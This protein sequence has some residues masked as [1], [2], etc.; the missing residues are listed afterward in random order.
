MS[1]KKNNAKNESNY[2]LSTLENQEYLFK[3]KFYKQELLVYEENK[4][5]L[6]SYILYSYLILITN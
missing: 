6:V 1:F 3:N 5:R 4:D 2:E